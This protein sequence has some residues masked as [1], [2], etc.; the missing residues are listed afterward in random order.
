MIIG[1]RLMTATWIASL[2]VLSCRATLDVVYV[3]MAYTPTNIIQPPKLFTDNPLFFNSFEDKRKVP[4]TIGENNEKENIVPVKTQPGEVLP[5]IENAF[6][7]E[8]RRAGFNIVDSKENASRIINVSLIN[9][10]VQ[11]RNLYQGSIVISLEIKDNSGKTLVTETF[12]GLEKRWGVSLNEK[13]YRK[14]L[15]DALVDLLNNVFK[16]N[17]F[18]KNLGS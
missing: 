16:D 18:M 12:R 8:F 14:T 17:G 4:D 15:S 9:L 3:K 6:K 10:W 13:D 1:K 5:F 11:E 2:L 7:R